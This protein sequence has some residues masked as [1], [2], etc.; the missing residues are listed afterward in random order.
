MGRLLRRD[1]PGLQGHLIGSAPPT[2]AFDRR[3]VLD[4]LTAEV[5][6]LGGVLS[7]LQEA[8]FNRPT[9]CRPW[10]VRDLVAHV[11]GAG[12][13]LPQMLRAPEPDHPTVTAAQYY[14]PDA[15]FAPEANATR[16]DVARSAAAAF[17]TG[18]DLVKAL[19]EAWRAMI[20]AAAAEP[21]SRMVRTRWDDDMWL[22]DFW[23]PG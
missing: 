15:R 13:R 9:R 11:L 22:T 14:R 17:P 3:D 12:D 7:R 4:A 6:G 5:D 18:A 19:D 2:S 16:I 10:S 1:H 20:A 8:D 21:E 23:S